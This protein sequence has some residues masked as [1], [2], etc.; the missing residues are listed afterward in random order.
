MILSQDSWLCLGGIF[1]LSCCQTIIVGTSHSCWIWFL[2][3]K[4][5]V[6]LFYSCQLFPSPFSFGVENMVSVHQIPY[7]C[8]SSFVTWAVN[9]T[10]SLTHTH[11]Y[12][13]H[14]FKFV[15]L[16]FT[17]LA[18]LIGPLRMHHHAGWL[19]FFSRLWISSFH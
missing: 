4:T 10:L 6:I 2:R 14:T 13:P 7:E 11:T 5:D 3:R 18:S 15:S 1:R 8:I 17:H 16:S 9:I 12:N 19:W